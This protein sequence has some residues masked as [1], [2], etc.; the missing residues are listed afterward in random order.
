[1][2]QTGM[3][4][5][6]ERSYLSYLLRFLYPG[7]H[8]LFGPKS[9]YRVDYIMAPDFDGEKH[10]RAYDTVLPLS[11]ELGIKVDKHCGRKDTDCVADT[12]SDKISA[13]RFKGDVLISWVS[14]FSSPLP[15]LLLYRPFLLSRNDLAPMYLNLN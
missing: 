7:D 14:T 2:P 15:L 11:R 8:Q 3:S 13:K 10:R 6:L 12:V 4:T 5:F 9:H 1:M